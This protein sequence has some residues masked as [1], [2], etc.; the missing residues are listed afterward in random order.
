MSYRHI[1]RQLGVHHQ[2]V[3]AWISTHGA[4]GGA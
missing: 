3:G 4:H 2:T 1:A